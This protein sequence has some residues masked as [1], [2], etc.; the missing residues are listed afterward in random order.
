MQIEQILRFLEQL[1]QQL[2]VRE[3]E[4]RNLETQLEVKSQVR[5]TDRQHEPKS[6][7]VLVG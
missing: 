1:A 6:S 4:L 2:N 7:G 5:Q 3:Q